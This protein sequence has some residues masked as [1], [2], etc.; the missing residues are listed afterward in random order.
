MAAQASEEAALWRPIVEKFVGHQSAAL[1]KFLEGRHET[2]QIDGMTTFT[3]ETR[4]FVLDAAEKFET[5][6]GVQRLSP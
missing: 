4:E 3:C 2:S 5:E 6:I 1:G